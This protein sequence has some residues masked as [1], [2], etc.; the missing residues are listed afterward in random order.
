MV[1]AHGSFQLERNILPLSVLEDGSAANIKRNLSKTVS[2]PNVS[3]ALIETH[4][5]LWHLKF[6]N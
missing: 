4:P 3:F 1:T 5:I 2:S 6:S